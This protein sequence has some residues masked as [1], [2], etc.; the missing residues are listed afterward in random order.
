MCRGQKILI[1]LLLMVVSAGCNSG[2]P[3]ESRLGEPAIRSGE[4]AI[5]GESQLKNLVAQ[6]ASLIDELSN[7]FCKWVF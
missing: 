1:G 5:Q 3:E 6:K 4:P 7:H 2:I